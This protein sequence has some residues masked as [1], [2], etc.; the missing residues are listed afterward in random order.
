MVHVENTKM[1]WT[2]GFIECP[3]YD[4]SN[5]RP[6]TNLLEEDQTFRKQT[7]GDESSFPAVPESELALRTARWLGG[8]FCSGVKAAP[9]YARRKP[10]KHLA[11]HFQL[12]LAVSSF[13][14]FL[15]SCTGS[16]PAFRLLCVI[17][18]VVHQVYLSPQ[19]CDQVST[20]C[21]KIQPTN[22]LSQRPSWPPTSQPC[23]SQLSDRAI[24]E[25]TIK[26]SAPKPEN[27]P[28]HQFLLVSWLSGLSYYF[29]IDYT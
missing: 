15:F 8:K 16:I 7:G 24:L 3:C 18:A 1:N 12:P 5:T 28:D 9:P 25:A 19:S 6:F 22:S 29:T 4:S 10:L 23:P 17:R 2:Q 13:R 27:N 26:I 14:R 20:E 21:P 11:P